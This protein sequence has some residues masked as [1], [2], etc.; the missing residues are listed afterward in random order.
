MK[1]RTNKINKKSRLSK[2]SVEDYL[3]RQ[4]ELPTLKFIT[5][6]SVDDGKST[7]I[8]RM[9]YEAQA[10]LEE[11]VQNLKKES[12]K[13]GTQGKDIDYALLVDGL[14]AE[15]EQGITIDVAYRFF[16]TENKR[17]IVA[18]APG[19]EEYTKNMIT[20]ASNAD[21]A[22]ILVDSRKGIL[23]QTRR[24][25]FLASLLGIK[26]IVLAI[27]KMDLIGYSQEKFNGIVDEFTAISDSL[28]FDSISHIPVSA[29]NGENIKI[30]STNLTWYKGPS[31]LSY[32][33]IFEKKPAEK[34]ALRFPVQY[35]LRPNQDFR[36]ICGM[37][38]SGSLA[39]G[40]MVKISSSKESVAIKSIFLGE[41]KLSRAIQGQSVCLEFDKDIDVSR[42]D[43]IVGDKETIKLSNLF[44]INLA[45][46]SVDECF[47]GR[48]YLFKAG[49]KY[50]K[51]RILDIKYKYNI[52][53]FEKLTS[54]SLSLNDIA[55]ATI[56]LEEEIIFDSYLDN[57]HTGSLILIDQVNHQTVGAATILHSLRRGTNIHKQKTNINRKNRELMNGHPGKL[58]WFTGLSGS[59]KSTVANALEVDLYKKG[60]KTYLLD[61]DNLRLGLNQDLGFTEA[62]R[63]ENIRRVG[64]VAKLMVDSGLFVLASFISPFEK[65]RQMVKDLFSIED[66]IEIYLS[67]SLEVS[68]SRDS[69]GLYKK[70]REGKLPNFTGISSPYEKPQNP[71]I[72]IDTND[73]T[74]NDSVIKIVSYLHF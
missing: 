65:D 13:Y 44:E 19:H 73:T 14:S 30:N 55:S 49:T 39:K 67:T 70:A 23:E 51:G 1:Q 64:E 68:E 28:N 5:C 2:D 50:V 58:I 29:L 35:I 63:I 16:S 66:Y 38:Q 57:R 34:E 43:V 45:W 9:L 24:H 8:G 40:D 52:N 4:E 25:S 60:I 26:D 53:N 37:I 18:D 72:T 74:I 7:L 20:G 33:E 15:R 47:K 54:N 46:L 22:I 32:L 27:N 12:M 41:K 62:D 21:L 42:G 3:K 10:L 69:K 71:N 31:L 6:G 56:Q 59:G 61:G 17:F 36:G 11:Q 48:K